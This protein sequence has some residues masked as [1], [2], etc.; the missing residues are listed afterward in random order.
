MLAL[1]CGDNKIV[2]ISTNVPVI[3]NESYETMKRI[4]KSDV[5]VVYKEL[6]KGDILHSY[7]DTR[8][9]KEFLR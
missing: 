9:A 7:L 4:F 2:N 6:K 1:N 5:K 8:L 3:V